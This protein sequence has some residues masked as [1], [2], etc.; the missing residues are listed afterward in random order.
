M[1]SLVLETQLSQIGPTKQYAFAP[2][3]PIKRMLS[4]Y[5]QVGSWDS[6]TRVAKNIIN[7]REGGKHVMVNWF[8][9]SYALFPPQ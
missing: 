8:I 9:D 2:E 1:I 7:P 6:V 4:L 5:Y 3:S